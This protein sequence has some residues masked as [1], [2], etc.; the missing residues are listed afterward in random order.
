MVVLRVPGEDQHSI[1]AHFQL[2]EA[3]AAQITKCFPAP[4]ELEFEK[5]MFPY[6]LYKKK[7]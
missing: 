4:I 1:A 2:A 3:V 6:L 7:R 5:C